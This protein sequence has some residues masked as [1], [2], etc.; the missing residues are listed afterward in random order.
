MEENDEISVL[1]KLIRQLCALD[2]STGGRWKMVDQ[3]AL[4]L[5]EVG[6]DGG[7]DLGD[8]LTIGKGY[9]E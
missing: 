3:Q 9:K 8:G 4:A 6:D 7:L 5:V 1:R 2:W